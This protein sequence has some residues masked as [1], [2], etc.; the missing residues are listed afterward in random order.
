MLHISTLLLF[1]SC[2]VAK[3]V[4][5]TSYGGEE[6]NDCSNPQAEF[7]PSTGYVTYK[8]F[9]AWCPAKIFN[10]C[11]S[12]TNY[13]RQ[14]RCRPVVKEEVIEEIFVDKNP[15]FDVKKLNFLNELDS[16]SLKEIF[17]ET[18][19]LN[20]LFDNDDD[21]DDDDE[22]RNIYEV[23]DIKAGKPKSSQKN[24]SK[25][26]G[27]SQV[28]KSKNECKF[29]CCPEGQ[30]YQSEID[31]CIDYNPGP[32]LPV[33]S[34]SDESSK[35]SPAKK[36]SVI[37]VTDSEQEQP[38]ADAPQTKPLLTS[39]GIA[40]GT[41]LSVG[42]FDLKNRCQNNEFYLSELDICVPLDK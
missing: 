15:L 34:S 36:P 17:D 24:K 6:S 32:P 9:C 28:K 2:V 31:I 38:Q 40:S 39:T 8:F 3:P 5:L 18:L 42:K 21:D 23:I 10:V 13:K 20:E 29:N 25:D 26:Q 16:D 41:V 37:Y 27:S 30:M 33:A 12:C 19:V 22:E 7:D 11:S 1:V 14:S 35:E 4:I